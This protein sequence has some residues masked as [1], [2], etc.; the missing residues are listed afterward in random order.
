MHQVPALT[1]KL[2]GRTFSAIPTGLR[3]GQS[4]QLK[5]SLLFEHGLSRK[6]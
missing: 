4:Y 1:Q 6:C 5:F 2:R 3:D